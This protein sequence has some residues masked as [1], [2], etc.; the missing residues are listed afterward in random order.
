[1]TKPNI[2]P[3][4]VFTYPLSY[5]RYV[6]LALMS[7][8]QVIYHTFRF[9]LLHTYFKTTTHTHTHI[10]KKKWKIKIRNSKSIAKRIFFCS[11][12]LVLRPLFSHTFES[13]FTVECICKWSIQDMYN[14]I[15]VSKPLSVRSLVPN[16]CQM[17]PLFTFIIST[18]YL[19]M[20]RI[21]TI[22]RIACL[23]SR[24]Y[25][26][27][28]NCWKSHNFVAFVSPIFHTQTDCTQH[29][30]NVILNIFK[31]DFN[32]ELLLPSNEKKKTKMKQETSERCLFRY[33]TSNSNFHLT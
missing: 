32:H 15:S 24:L 25:R 6:T 26:L 19:P 29:I 8:T 20:Y 23:V 13:Y 11:S 10:R 21:W 12:L 22:N 16:A 33:R 18:M 28:K 3:N 9:V 5:E 4:T 2:V 1:M 31:T 30:S 14:E 27:F 17:Y 7:A